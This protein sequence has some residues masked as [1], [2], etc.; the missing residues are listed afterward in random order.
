M[1]RGWP[2][3]VLYTKMSLLYVRGPNLNGFSRLATLVETWSLASLRDRTWFTWG[4]WPI[5][6]LQTPNPAAL[7]INSAQVGPNF[8][9]FGR[10]K[11]R[12]NAA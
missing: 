5:N 2:L 10:D 1:Q 8:G 9:E 3:D 11:T 6:N 7:K 12:L 4:A